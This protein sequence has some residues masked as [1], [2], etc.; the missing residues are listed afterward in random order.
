MYTVA[1]INTNN[2]IQIGDF[3]EFKKVNDDNLIEEFINFTGMQK[4]DLADTII[5]YQE[6]E[7]LYQLCFLTDDN[8]NIDKNNPNILASYL[9]YE[10]KAIRGNVILM[11]THLPIN[12]FDMY[13]VDITTADIEKILY[14]KKKTIGVVIDGDNLIEKEYDYLDLT[15]FKDYERLEIALYK[16]N[17]EVYYKNNGIKNELASKL[18]CQEMFGEVYIY[19]KLTED[20]YDNLSKNDINMM[21]Q[22]STGNLDDNKLTEEELEERKDEKDRI[23]I[24]SK[25]RILYNKYKKNVK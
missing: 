16:Y 18:F 6:P 5:C 11:V 9:T 14:Y 24:N 4:D 12:N 17:L 2:E 1:F 13:N 20:I 7:K 10:N 22:L 23:I 15:N 25:Y 19:S 8:N 3:I 21:I